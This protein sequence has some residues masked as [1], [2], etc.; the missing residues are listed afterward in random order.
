MGVYSERAAKKMS[1][2][3]DKAK[4]D[5][6]KDADD[7]GKKHKD[8]SEKAAKCWKSTFSKIGSFSAKA[9]NLTTK[10]VATGIT[11]TTTATA[12]L[13]TSAVGAYAEYEQLIGGV[14]TLFNSSTAL[15]GTA[16]NRVLANANNAYKSAG[17][18]AN[19][20]MET[21]TSFSAS[22]LQSL[23]GDTQAAVDKADM[24]I[25]DMSDNANKMGTSMEMIQYAYQGFAKQNYTML[26]NLKLGYGGTKEEMQRLLDKANEINAQQG[27]ITDYQIESY[28][29]VVD[30]IHVIQTEMGITGTTAREAS[31]T[32]EGSMNAAKAAWSNLLV[33]IADDNQ[34]FDQLVNNFVDSVATAAGN[35]LPRI[36]TSITGV[37][38]LIEKLFPVIMAEIPS[39]L[40]DV[41]PD[42]VASGISMTNSLISGIEQNLLLITDTV[43]NIG[44]Q[45]MAALI[46]VVPQFVVVGLEL[47]AQ[48][49]LGI[50]QALPELLPKMTEAIDTIVIAIRDNLPI[51]LDAGLQIL[52]Q[53]AI[54]IAHAL[55]ELI[56]VIVDTVLLIVD[57]LLNNIDLLADAAV[58]LMLG[59]ALGLVNAIP[60]LIEKVPEIIASLLSA[61]CE[62]APKLVEAASTMILVIAK[63]LITYLPFLLAM[64][65]DLVLQINNKFISLAGKFLE[66]GKSY[67]GKIKE[68]IISKWEEVKGAVPT[69]VSGLVD[70]FLSKVSEFASIGSNIVQGIWNGIS[71]GWD[72]LISKVSGLAT[73]LLQA[74][75]DTLGIHSPSQEFEYIGRMCTAGFDKGSDGLMDPDDISKDVKASLGTVKANVEGTVYAGGGGFKQIVNINQQVSTPDELA[76]AVRVESRYG[77]MRGV[78]VGV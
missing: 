27:I 28:A 32:I 74:A 35:I 67:I 61:L 55:P 66:V 45:L 3:S 60:V 17:L 77:M 2:S 46:E 31:S 53:L 56:P 78:P 48:L 26:D 64:V 40:N 4:K 38:K 11:L 51:I 20:Y 75:K 76:R 50:A 14:E 5:V 41:L 29:D 49:A 70:S 72:W 25:T 39:V 71:S 65:P 36:E 37:G 7:M 24:A 69:W 13:V 44:V 57:T 8:S 33:G 68:S 34:D 73:N 23:D 9:I 63:A 16:A 58:Q 10:A 1:E 18:S 54:G 12:A 22:L 52:L 6:D 19:A 30:A 62:N 43:S 21:V 59:L 47:I 42:L 15:F